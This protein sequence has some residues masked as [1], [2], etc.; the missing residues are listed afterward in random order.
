MS[1][2]QF[3]KYYDPDPTVTTHEYILYVE[4]SDPL[5]DTLLEWCLSNSLVDENKRWFKNTNLKWLEIEVT[6]DEQRRLEFD[7]TFR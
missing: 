6:M 5:K 7:L 1:K 3:F 4:Y 2:I